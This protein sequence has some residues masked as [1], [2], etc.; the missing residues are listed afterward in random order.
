MH[1]LESSSSL[2][3]EPAADVPLSIKPEITPTRKEIVVERR[4]KNA[5]SF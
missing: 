4:P 5:L 2:E 1:Y 3:V